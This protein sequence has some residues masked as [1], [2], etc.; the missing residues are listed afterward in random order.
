[1]N[2]AH[3]ILIKMLSVLLFAIMSALIRWLGDRVPLGQ[4]V[5][6]RSAFA[7]LPVLAIY[8]WRRELISAVRTERPFGHLGRGM[9]SVAGMFL[10]FA[11]LA[12]LPLADANALSFASPLITVALAALILKE[13][14]RVYRWTA[15]AIGF[16]GVVVMLSPYLDVGHMT[17]STEA[18]IGATCAITAAFTNAGSVIQTRRLT[19]SETTSSIVFYFSF[20]CALIGACTLPFAWHQP[21]LAEL[22]ALIGIGFIGGVSHIF[23][24]E[25]YRYAAAS[26][27]AP[28]DYAAMLW[29]F[30]FG[31]W[32]FDEV[33]TVHVFIGSGIV[34]A[35]GLFVLWRERRRGIER[36]RTSAIEGPPVGEMASPR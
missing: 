30:L 28:F 11:A 7:I 32:L 9:I 22:A 35:S 17:A 16:V 4:V 33:P 3:A 1:M 15:V 19:D 26:V 23:L 13:E 31:Y 25:S 21:T 6:F 24:T 8:A 34:A 12:R 18:S 2:V 5:F 27:V 14:V 36:I 20:I 29:A 10:N